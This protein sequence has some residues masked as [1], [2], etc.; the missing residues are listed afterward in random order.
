MTFEKD[1]SLN[2]INLSRI[3]PSLLICKKTAGQMKGGP[4]VFIQDRKVPA[5]CVTLGIIADDQTGAPHQRGDKE[6]LLQSFWPMSMSEWLP[7]S[8]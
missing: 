7:F 2:I 5:L 4:L 8:A 1:F 6:A 3:D